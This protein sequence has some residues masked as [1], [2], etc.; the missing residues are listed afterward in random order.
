MDTN[1]DDFV[2]AIRSA[3]LKKENKQRFSLTALIFF[4]ILFLTLGR[5]NF[6]AIDYVKTII[7][8]IVYR[9]SFIVSVPENFI[10]NSF[11]N[12]SDHFSHY[13]KYQKIDTELNELKSK[14]LSRKI[15]T[16]EN[17]KLKKLID[18][19][20]ITDNEIFA[21]VLIDKNSPFLRSVVL[22]KGSKDNIQLG[23]AV[24]DKSNLVGKVVEVNYSTSRVLLISD[25][26]AKIPVSLEPGDIQA[27][28]SGTGKQNGIIQ[29]TKEIY[30]KKNPANMIVF[31]SGAGG[32]FKSGIPIGTIEKNNLLPGKDKII[33]FYTDF[34]QLQYV[35]II[36]Y[37]QEQ[38]V[39]NK[40]NK[41]ITKI[42]DQIKQIKKDEERLSILLEQK[43]INEEIRAK[44]E[45]ENSLL[46]NELIKLKKEISVIKKTIE[47]DTTRS[48]EIQFIKLNNQY[49]KKCKKTFFNKLFKEGSTEYK[50]CVL[51]KGK[52]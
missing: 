38:N 39:F 51:N 21:K 34:S 9:S 29:H 35:K 30:S 46:K 16:L 23:M 27:I 50:T 40:S 47:D 36:S 2:I 52:N 13:K 11:T 43:K 5:L 17:N 19:Y 45:E 33:N 12:V 24:L 32:V 1:R 3:F 14:D 8:E 44:I 10:A 26:N 20:F 6:T 37:S 4:S 41:E 28:M 7:K 18:D 42:D 15:I 25:L 48:K 22:N 49:G 31:T